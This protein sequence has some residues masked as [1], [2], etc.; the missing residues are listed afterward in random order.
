M[1]IVQMQVQLDSGVILN[2]QQFCGKIS[3]FQSIPS[4]CQKS[5]SRPTQDE[6]EKVKKVA[7]SI[8]NSNL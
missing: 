4:V 8:F 5:I 1:K 7:T 6:I 3:V 2:V